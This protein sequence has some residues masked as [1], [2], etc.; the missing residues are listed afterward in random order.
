MP[1]PLKIAG[2]LSL[3]GAICFSSYRET[4]AISEG[5]NTTTQ[6]PAA[7]AAAITA[8]RQLIR[9]PPALFIF[10]ASLLLPSCSILSTSAPRVDQQSSPP[11]PH[12]AHNRYEQTHWSAERLPPASRPR[13]AAAKLPLAAPPAIPAA[14]STPSPAQSE[15]LPYP[16]TGQ[17][18]CSSPAADPP[19]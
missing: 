5:T 3:T 15:S 14:Q 7:P 16:A 10:L 8:R 4:C 2:G 6:K 1:T 11:A 13:S 17:P 9:I 18:N 12:P 19:W